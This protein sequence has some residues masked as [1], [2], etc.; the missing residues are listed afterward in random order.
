MKLEE[1]YHGGGGGAGAAADM[2][3][4][5]HHPLHDVLAPPALFAS[6]IKGVVGTASRGGLGA[7]PPAASR[8]LAELRQELTDMVG[9]VKGL[10]TRLPAEAQQQLAAMAAAA[11]ASL[12]E[13]QVAAVAAAD[14]A[15]PAAARQAMAAAAQRG[16]TS[17]LGS[18]RTQMSSLMQ[19]YSEVGA[20]AATVDFMTAA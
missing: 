6:P 12:Q 1:L 18:L 8:L 3:A 14:A 9:E 5:L 17:A 2:D 4:V 7:T 15:Q 16:A 19:L 20:A 11:E 13:V 10:Q